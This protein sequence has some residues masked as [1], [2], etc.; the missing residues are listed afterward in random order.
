[1][2]ILNKRYN[3]Y[4]DIKGVRHKYLMCSDYDT[5][6]KREKM[7][8]SLDS[9]MHECSMYEC[10]HIF[11]GCNRRYKR[12]TALKDERRCTEYKHKNT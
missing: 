10:K 2:S 9:Q 4:T 6:D 1:M 3:Y 11:S 8:K 7:D 5:P 12:P